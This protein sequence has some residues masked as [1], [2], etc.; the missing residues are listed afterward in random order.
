V[1]VEIRYFGSVPGQVSG[2]FQLN[3][4][5]PPDFVTADQLPIELMVGGAPSPAGV[6]VAI[7]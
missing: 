6:T 4:Y 5:L 2:M 1:P 3:A 7:R